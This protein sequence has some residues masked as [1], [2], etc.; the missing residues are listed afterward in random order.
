M[1]ALDR[2]HVRGLLD[3]ADDL[4]IAPLVG[5][6]PA[7]RS[8]GQ[9]EARGAQADPLLDLLDRVGQREGLLVAGA[10][11]VKGQPLSAPAADPGQLGQLGDQPLDGWGVD[12]QGEAL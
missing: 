7:R 5:A 12:G 11:Q 10:Q 8:I 6:D 4:R 9:V 1:C 2:D 3:H